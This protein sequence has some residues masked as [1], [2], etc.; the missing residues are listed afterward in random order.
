MVLRGVLE[1]DEA[2]GQQPSAHVLHFDR[3][4]IEVCRCGYSR[5]G[6]RVADLASGGTE[7]VEVGREQALKASRISSA[8]QA[9]RLTLGG[10]GLGD[11]LV[12]GGLSGG[13]PP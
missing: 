10:R 12:S 7:L 4:A 9:Q 13:L 2:V 5:S 8:L 3:L 6:S 11:L 1:H